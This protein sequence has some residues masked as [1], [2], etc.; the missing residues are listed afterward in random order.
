MAFSKCL[1]AVFA[2]QGS[3]ALTLPHTTPNC[4][5]FAHYGAAGT[6]DQKSSVLNTTYYAAGALN[7]SGVVNSISF[8]E[9][10][11]SIAY[12]SG[13]DTLVFALWLPDVLQ[14]ESRFMAVGN[15]GGTNR[16][17]DDSK[18]LSS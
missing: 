10:Y 14:Y 7:N 2:V 16:G 8:C 5:H 11:G 6:Y 15:G 4:S 13:S 1:Y 3:L 18:H 9:I 17:R 12:G